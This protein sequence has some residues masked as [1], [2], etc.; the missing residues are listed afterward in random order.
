MRYGNSNDVI[1]AI[2]SAAKRSICNEAAF[3]SVGF[4]NIDF[5]EVF[6]PNTN[7]NVVTIGF[8]NCRF[9]NCKIKSS[10]M[11]PA[12]M[13]FIKFFDCRFD[14]C[15]ITPIDSIVTV[16]RTYITNCTIKGLTFGNGRIQALSHISIIDSTI[17]SCISTM[18]FNVETVSIGAGHDGKCLIED[19]DFSKL[20]CHNIRIANDVTIKNTK[21]PFIRNLCPEEGEFIGWKKVSV[22]GFANC[23]CKLLI[24]KDAKRLS[25]ING[26]CRCDKAKVLAFYEIGSSEELTNCIGYSAYRFR[27]NKLATYY[28]GECVYADSFDADPIYECSHGIHFF[29]TREEAER[30]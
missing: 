10:I 17:Y 29:M 11:S 14:N 4:E 19:C 13:I 22:N 12:E 6:D 16:Y 8:I 26:K 21:L 5:S 18:R 2:N 23:I 3:I 27:G 25:S 15:I 9:Y 24:P 30:Y 20:N 28:V 7:T 1:K